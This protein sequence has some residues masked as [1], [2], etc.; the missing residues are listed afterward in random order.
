M[1]GCDCEYCR[2]RWIEDVVADACFL[3][4]KVI[5]VQGVLGS[6]PGGGKLARRMVR[7]LASVAERR[8][9]CAEVAAAER[10]WDVQ[11]A[12]EAREAGR[13]H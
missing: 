8:G 1:T 6:G 2:A 10:A 13:L 3:E 4:E 7:S 5:E 9:L 12:A 11:T